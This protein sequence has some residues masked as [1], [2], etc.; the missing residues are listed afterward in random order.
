MAKDFYVT[1]VTRNAYATDILSRIDN[2]ASSGQLRIYSGAVP[3]S[4]DDTES[5]NEQ[6][7][8]DLQEPAFTGPT[9]GVLTLS[10]TPSGTAG[11]VP[12]GGPV[13]THFRI[14][15]GDT[16]GTRTCVCQGT[17]GTSDADLVLSN[18]NIAE[19]DEITLQTLEI[20]VPNSLTTVP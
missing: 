14:Y 19:N 17:C 18:V 5:T 20:T 6:V 16:G 11:A 9:N 3:T 2:G 12:G 10:G 1:N 15:D 8:I 7:S 13:A 4:A